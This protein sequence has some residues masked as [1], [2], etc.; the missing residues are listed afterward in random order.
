MRDPEVQAKSLLRQG[1]LGPVVALGD[2]PAK[3]AEIL[4]YEMLDLAWGLG[5][6]EYPLEIRYLEQSAAAYLHV[7]KVLCGPASEWYWFFRE[8]CRMLR[9]LKASRPFLA[10]MARIYKVWEKN[11]RWKHLGF[12]A[13]FPGASAWSRCLTEYQDD[14]NRGQVPPCPEY[15]AERKR[16]L[17]AK[18][19][20]QGK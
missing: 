8:I 12:D 14:L 20:T 11:E 15:I 10:C 2:V 9:R 16:A 4:V 19:S 6:A 3:A 7:V 5:R 17:E 1:R 18:A 13:Y